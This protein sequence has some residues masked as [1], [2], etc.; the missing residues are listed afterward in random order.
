MIIKIHNNARNIIIILII[1]KTPS[2][3]KLYEEQMQEFED[4][5][6]YLKQER[7]RIEND[8]IM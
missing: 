8:K 2:Q 1:K 4:Q 7:E 6:T 5:L 3:Q